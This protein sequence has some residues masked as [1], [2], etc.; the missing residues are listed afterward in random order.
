LY[1]REGQGRESAIGVRFRASI[2][3][4]LSEKNGVGPLVSDLPSSSS[5]AQSR[6]SWQAVE[7]KRG[8][9]KEPV[10]SRFADKRRLKFLAKQFH[11][12]LDFDVTVTQGL[13]ENPDSPILGT[14]V[15]PEWVDTLSM[16]ARLQLL[17]ILTASLRFQ[18]SPAL[19]VA[20]AGHVT[21]AGEGG[22]GLA[23]TEYLARY[24]P[25]MRK[26]VVVLLHEAVERDRNA[27]LLR[28]VE[29]VLWRALKIEEEDMS[30]EELS[31][32]ATLT[33][34]TLSKVA[35][36][37]GPVL[38]EAEDLIDTLERSII[39]P[40]SRAGSSK[41][42]S[43]AGSR[44][45]SRAGVAVVP[46]DIRVPMVGPSSSHD[47]LLQLQS[48]QQQQQK[49][50]TPVEQ[51]AT[52]LPP[53]PTG[54]LTREEALRL[55][56]ERSALGKKKADR[57]PAI[58]V[59]QLVE[60][61]PGQFVV[62]QALS[63]DKSVVTLSAFSPGPGL[64]AGEMDIRASSLVYANGMWHLLMR[65]EAE[66]LAHAAATSS[67]LRPNQLE[68]FAQSQSWRPYFVLAPPA[69]IDL[70]NAVTGTERSAWKEVEKSTEAV[71]VDDPVGLMQT[72]MRPKSFVSKVDTVLSLK[73]HEDQLIRE[74]KKDKDKEKQ[75]S[76]GVADEPQPDDV[77]FLTGVP[78]MVAEQRP[79]AEGGEQEDGGG[80]GQG[81]VADGGDDAEAGGSVLERLNIPPEEELLKPTPRLTVADVPR[82]GHKSWY[83][84]PGK[85]RSVVV[86]GEAVHPFLRPKKPAFLRAMPPRF[87]AS[88]P[89]AVRHKPRPTILRRS[90]FSPADGALTPSISAH[91]AIHNLNLSSLTP[92]SAQREALPSV[93][94]SGRA[95]AAA[96]HPAPSSSAPAAVTPF[97][98]AEDHASHRDRPV[99]PNTLLHGKLD[100]IFEKRVGEMG[101]VEFYCKVAFSGG[102][103]RQA[104]RYVWLNQ[105]QLPDISK[106][107]LD[108][109][110]WAEAL[111]AVT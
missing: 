105:K 94:R 92:S 60:A 58:G 31:A 79:G 42:G 78:G 8:F 90:A 56:A 41:A 3:R 6:H 33:A 15:D 95:A 103:V 7:V 84:V 53:L 45:Q 91:G 26:A 4:G 81:A 5:G 109:V 83:V 11:R 104:P 110:P 73:W 38:Q 93:L 52:A 77:T 12:D 30:P 13:A 10:N 32:L 65:T 47:D 35:F 57:A 19:L 63:Q 66:A 22:G 85:P 55:Q 37:E 44:P 36:E 14:P 59:G 17:I 101:D 75:H 1:F 70:V 82:A 34:K 49:H 61:T 39:R 25:F 86:A 67:T 24:P 108:S 111:A 97:E 23:S 106:A 96:R 46:V 98:D 107:L 100:R 20:A 99:S 88:E 27:G 40:A 28:Q 9:A 64:P 76:A 21:G 43:R 54:R 69:A 16:E 102:G 87:Q 89:A 51:M 71:R 74:M 50:Q 2:D 68:I 48:K 29:L 62:I 72:N 18:I 80:D